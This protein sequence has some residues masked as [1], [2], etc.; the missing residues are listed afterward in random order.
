MACLPSNTGRSPLRCGWYALAEDLAGA[1]VQGGEQV[2]GA[3]AAVVVGAFLGH[4]ELDGQQGLG[5][6]QG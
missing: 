2:R 3:V 6:V 1:D 4:V 5:A